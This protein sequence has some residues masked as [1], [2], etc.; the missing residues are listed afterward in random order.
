MLR[1]SVTEENLRI[2]EKDTKPKSQHSK[3][4]ISPT[5]HIP[6]VP[7]PSSPSKIKSHGPKKRVTINLMSIQENDPQSQNRYLFAKKVGTKTTE[8]TPLDR[9]TRPQKI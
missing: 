7:S 3:H 2:G 1:R 8:G 4:A 6:S 9:N 5:F